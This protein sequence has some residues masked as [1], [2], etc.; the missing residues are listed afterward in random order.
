VI[1]TKQK[2]VFGKLNFEGEEQANGFQR[3]FATVNIVPK[4]QIIGIRREPAVPKTCMRL[5][6]E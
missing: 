1:A 4:E 5:S 3:L 2:K 6:M